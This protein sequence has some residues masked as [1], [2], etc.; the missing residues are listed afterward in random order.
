MGPPNANENTNEQ[1]IDYSKF[2]SYVNRLTHDW[3]KVLT[4]IVIV[5][6]PLFFVLDYF[7]APEE[8][9]HSFGVFRLAVTVITIVQHL[10]IRFTKS[11][12]NSIIH[13]YIVSIVIAGMITVMTVN[14][15]GFDSG[16][17]AGLNLVII[18][19]A[20][21]LPWKP[22][23]GAANSL[24]IIGM[25]LF[26]NYIWGDRG[27][28]LNKLI[29][30]LYFMSSTIVITISISYVRFN[31]T[32]KEFHQRRELSAAQVDEIRDLAAVSQ[33]VATGDLSVQI[34]K[35][36][37]HTA[38][39][40]E[41]SFDKMVRDL[42]DTLLQ[43]KKISEYISDY[44]G[45]IS[46]ITNYMASGSKEQLDQTTKSTEIVKEVTNIII[47]SSEKASKIDEMADQA[48][49][50]AAQSSKFI[51]EAVTGMSRIGDVVN[52]SARKVDSLSESSE[53]INEI[54]Q[55]I[56]EIA[57]QTNLLALNAAI[58]A[59]HHGEEGKGFAI[60]ADEVGKLSDRTTQATKEI[61]A[62]IRNVIEDIS[63]AVESMSIATKEVDRATHLVGEMHKS[64]KEIIELSTNLR[65]MIS[66]IARASQE[67]AVG[68][69]QVNN[70][71]N[72]INEI[73]LSLTNSIDEIS[74]TI[75]D[76]NFF[77]KDLEN[78]VNKFKL[79]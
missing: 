30:N 18:V 7:T 78:M 55:V 34:E 37:G 53:K 72:S 3:L 40:L 4:M 36:S 44:S 14:L 57:G 49:N 54:I 75:K 22:V 20:L 76:M 69:G 21:L 8:L 67:Q 12:F 32:R 70:N 68:A 42:R 38:G 66:Q 46:K 6:V 43:I 5:L 10:V 41:E 1:K 71:I 11:G 79:Q 15:G 52:D 29:N 47:E 56:T 58:E 60:V 26:A 13:G 74:H 33:V 50:T 64:T 24:L 63:G 31:L 2:D 16:Y 45:I 17:Y 61:S 19:I 77:T 35:K 28:E 62:M 65:N 59:A 48:I 9:V 25:Y 27:Y 73:A 23:H 39:M 51:D